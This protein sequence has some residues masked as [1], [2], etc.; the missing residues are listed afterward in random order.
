MTR[1]RLCSLILPL[2][3][4]A[5]LPVGAVAQPAEPT[6]RIAVIS[7]FAPEFDALA[8]FLDGA[9]E[10]VIN[11]NRFLTGRIEGR[12]VVLF[13]SGVSMVNAAMTTQLALGHFDIDGIVVSGI[14]G[15]VDPTLAI[16]DVVVADRWGQYLETVFARETADGFALPPWM[17]SDFP[18]YGMMF[19]RNVDVVSAR[20]DAPESRFWFP[21]D[22]GFLALAAE[23]AEA[24]TLSACDA[25]GNCLSHEPEIIVGGAGVSG[26]TFV[27]NA[28]FR[29]F[30]F[31]TFE[32]QVL[33]MESAAVAHVAHANQVPFIAFRSLSDLAGGGDDDN[34]LPVFLE[35]AAGNS[36]AVVRAFLAGMGER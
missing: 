2:A 27:D 34:E 12:D 20:Q 21:V 7:A 3:A 10:Q 13:Q 22:A 6:W 26:S 30:V 19:T 5:A 24:V 9:S 33:D 15:G 28:A 17:S 32:A 36:A 31:A 35:L 11:G 4:V 25:E 14:A 1:I 18:N 8:G 29:E 23:V 16:G